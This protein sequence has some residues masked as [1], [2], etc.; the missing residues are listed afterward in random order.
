[1]AILVLEP[2]PVPAR[3]TEL[4]PGG[5]RPDDMVADATACLALAAEAPVQEMGDE[6]LG[7]VIAGLAQLESRAAALRMS[8]STEADQRRVSGRTAETGTDAWLARLTGTTRGQAAG[9]L[10]IA[11]LL[12]EKYTTT[13]AAFAAGELR[14][15]QVKVIVHAAEQAPAEATTAQI[16]QAEQWLVAQAT[17]TGTRTGQG[18]DATRLRHTARRMFARIDHDLADR[19]EAILLGRETRS[20]EAETF[21]AL[22]DNGNGTF[23]GKFL[24]S[25]LHGHLL[26]QALDR[27]TSP[28]RLCRDRS[29]QVVVDETAPG[30]G[31]GANIYETHGAALC[32]LIEHLPTTGWPGHAGNGCEVIVKLDLDALRTGIGVAG[33]DTGVVLTAGEARR[34]AC[35]AGIIPAVLDGPSMPLD[36]G[37]SRRLH[38]RSQRRSYALIHD[39]CAIAGCTRP[40]AWCEIHHHRI[41]WSRG[42]PTDLDNGLPL[43]GHHHR[44][45]HDTH[46][47]L[48]P[49][50]DGEWTFHRRT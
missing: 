23:S 35:S 22:H 12:T 49:R 47:D 48:R 32:E 42:G 46:F 40:F 41:P 33:L 26:T 15:E 6:A 24:I 10:R 9:A 1:M 14:L 4:R 5:R 43:C 37:R 19:H 31:Y 7:T 13:R 30:T 18:I 36:L 34:L 28:R 8:L 21:L 45:V 17:G 44:R 2:A 20:A 27:L 39:T 38:N 11:R 25:E 50:P 3:A 29:G 16:A